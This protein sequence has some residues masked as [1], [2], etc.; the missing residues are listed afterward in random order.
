MAETNVG[1]DRGMSVRGGGTA[2][3][4]ERPHRNVGVLVNFGDRYTETA[5]LEI[6]TSRV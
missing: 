2:R 3:S 6:L 4:I 5:G 1:L